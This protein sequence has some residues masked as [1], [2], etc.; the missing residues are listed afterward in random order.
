MNNII[1]IINFIY[2]LNYNNIHQKWTFVSVLSDIFSSAIA[3]FKKVWNPTKPTILDRTHQSYWGTY[4]NI[5]KVSGE[6]GKLER[7]IFGQMDD[8]DKKAEII[9][10]GAN[11][12]IINLLQWYCGKT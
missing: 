3:L 2:N 10:M 1:I 9:S 11:T 8:H 5:H 6:I 4:Q 12:S 7:L